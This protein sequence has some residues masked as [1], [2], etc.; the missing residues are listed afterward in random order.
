M[1]PSHSVSASM[2]QGNPV[3]ISMI[4][5]ILLA[6]LLDHSEFLFVNKRRFGNACPWLITLSTQHESDDDGLVYPGEVT[7]LKQ[8]GK[9]AEIE[10]SWSTQSAVSLTHPSLLP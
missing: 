1:R 5:R 4:I 2:I 3:D 7:R 8:R 6:P 10:I 9:S